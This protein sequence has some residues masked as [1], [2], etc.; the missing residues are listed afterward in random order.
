MRMRQMNI[1]ARQDGACLQD[2]VA[3]T[4]SISRGKAKDL[5]DTR[6]VF[7]NR[8]RVWMARHTLRAG[9][10]LEFPLAPPAA[11]QARSTAVLFQDTDYVVADKPAGRLANGADSA[12]SELRRSLD[13]ATLLAV[14]RLDRDTSGCLL[15]AKRQDAFD[16]AIPLFR[17]RQI[18]KLYETI[19][20]GPIRGPEQTISTPI[21]G[22]PA[23]THVRV[24]DSNA[25]AS[26]LRV[27]IDTGRTH[28]IRKHLDSIGHPVLG[29]KAYGTGRDL[30]AECRHVPRQMLHAAA[31]QF[32]SPFTGKT[33]RVNA[34]LPGDFAACLRALRLR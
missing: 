31:L 4:L 12:E 26:H 20:A 34:P 29:D 24:L 2:I 14:H 1:T 21:D 25:A 28:Q 11:T 10:V 15:L 17:H 9:D 16:R 33:I 3:D 7:V 6:Q 13:L 22:E 5:I 27:K 23:M 32:E 19:V 30:P 18:L 8:R